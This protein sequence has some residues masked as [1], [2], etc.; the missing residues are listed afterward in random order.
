MMTSSVARQWDAIASAMAEQVQ[1][2]NDRKAADPEAT[3]QIRHLMAENQRLLDRLTDAQRLID[4]L[5]AQLDD[6]PRPMRPAQRGTIIDP[7][8]GRPVG[9]QSE[10]ARKHRCAPYQVSRWIAA[11]KL[12]TT[13]KYVFLDQPIPSRSR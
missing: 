9:T 5:K 3:A 12:A 7:T 13:G 1:R 4:D 8:T 2:V 10:F 6:T 11:G